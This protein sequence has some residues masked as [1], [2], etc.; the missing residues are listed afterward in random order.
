MTITANLDDRE[1]FL[2]RRKLSNRMKEEIDNLLNS[3][4]SLK[5][6]KMSLKTFLPG[7]RLGYLL[8]PL[9]FDIA[10]ADVARVG[11]N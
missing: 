4:R 10:L 11:T 2:E 9:L 8:L 7:T 1:T 3:P 5:E 6:I